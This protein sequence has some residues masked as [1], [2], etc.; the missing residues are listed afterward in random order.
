M[1]PEPGRRTVAV[2]LTLLTA[3]TAVLLVAGITRDLPSPEPD[4]PFFVLPAVR[5]AAH[6]SADPGW[7]GHPGSTVIAP[8]ALAYRAREVVFHGAPVFG[9]APSLLHRYREDPSSFYLL[10]RLWTALLTLATVPLVYLVGRRI[11]S[12]LAG[13]LGAGAWVVL[14]LVLEYGRLVRTDAA[15]TCFGL[16]ALLAALR[17]LERPTLSRFAAAG[18]LVGLAVATRWFMLTL[19][20]ALVGV[21]WYTL[22][23]AQAARVR[24]ARLAIACGAALGT[25]AAITPAFF[26]DWTAVQR[27]VLAEDAGHFGNVSLGPLDN[28]SY[29]LFHALPD[30]LSWPGYVLAIAGMAVVVVRKRPPG[31]LTVA[32]VCTFLAALVPAGLHWQRWLIPV[33]PFLALFAAGAVCAGVASIVR[34]A[35]ARGAR[36][37]PVLVGAVV[38]G[39][40]AVTAVSLVTSGFDTYAVTVPTTRAAMRDDVRR[41]VPKGD[42]VAVE[43]KGPSLGDVGYPTYHVFDLPRNGTVADYAAHGYH[44]FVVNTYVALQYRLHPNRWRDHT[45]FYQFLRWH[46][47]LLADERPGDAR[48][49]PHLKLYRVDDAALAQ[50][51]GRPVRATTLRSSHDRVGRPSHKYPGGGRLFD[52]PA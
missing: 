11:L 49:G 42:E 3:L 47:D 36:R 23:D 8:L 2:V 44:Y 20:V 1:L 27:S 16:L 24:W 26:V 40:V 32:F 35:A 37:T 38:V 7:F 5:M 30:A 25:F 46:G 14:P 50:H 12:P 9:D 45:A 13:L 43:V 39:M 6:D 18:A 28:L 33:L 4:E 34:T 41:V 29:Y 21:W 15:A 48:Q 19:F 51:V 10:G 31:I 22:R 17:A 52:Q